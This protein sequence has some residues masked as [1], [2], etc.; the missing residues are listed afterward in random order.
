MPTCQSNAVLCA[1]VVAGLGCTS[2]ASENP[3]NP[4]GE[5][6]PKFQVASPEVEDAVIVREHV[7]EIRAVRHAELR[8]REKGVL[9]RVSVDEGQAVQA[10]QTLFSVNARALKQEVLVAKAAVLGAEAE[11]KAA[12]LELQNTKLLQEKNVVSAAELALAES[13]VL[14]L[15]AKVQEA[16]AISERAA[17]ELSYAE[18][19][20]PFAGVVNRIPHKAGSAVGE[21]ELLT[22]LTDTSEVFAYF[23]I[24]ERDYLALL[25]GVGGAGGSSKPGAKDGGKPDARPDHVGLLLADGRAYPAAGVVDAIASELDRETGTLAYRARFANGDGVLKHGSSGKVVVRTEVP[26]ALLIAQKATFD[27][28]GDLYVYILDGR[29]V[30][31]ARKIAVKTRLGE[32]FVVESGLQ[33]TDRFILEGVQKVKEGAPIEVA[34]AAPTARVDSGRGR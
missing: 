23:R 19:K 11:R 30:P 12:Q 31:K 8:A 2:S 24:T 15:E 22:T 18:V 20:A 28:Q 29:N 27:L 6:A 3:D 16:K 7:A 33:P 14:S 9:E 32:R 4:R 1:L 17:V 13:K 25:D 10:G 5:G 26:G 21:D 34:N